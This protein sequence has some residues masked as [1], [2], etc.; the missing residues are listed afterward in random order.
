MS[1]TSESKRYRNVC[2]TINNPTE[3][4]RELLEQAFEDGIITYMIQGEEVGKEGTPHIQGYLELK[5]QLRMSSLKKFM[6]RAHIEARKGTNKQAILYCQKDG[7]YNEWG[8][9]KKP[10]ARTDLKQVKKQVNE[11]A[12]M[13]DILQDSFNYQSIKFAEKMIQY[14]PLSKERHEI[15]VVW[16]WGATGSGK[17]EY[18]YELMGPDYWRS[19]STLQWFDGYDKNPHVLIN[20]FRADFCPLHTLLELL[21]GYDMRVPIKGGFT[22]WSPRYIVITSIFHPSMV[23]SGANNPEPIKQLLRRIT[24][25]IEMINWEPHGELK[26]D[27]IVIDKIKMIKEA[28][29]NTSNT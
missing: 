17:T 21:D 6:P 1:Q 2:F 29:G 16:L 14:A 19:N 8:T 25:T 27:Q 26:P 20:E 15:T 28:H 22:I 13:W 5:N 18:G 9:K 11:G 23:Y 12:K 4:D 3:Q 24:H 7:I 10:G